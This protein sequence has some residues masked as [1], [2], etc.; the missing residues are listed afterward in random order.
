MPERYQYHP[1]QDA[2]DTRQAIEHHF[3]WRE[4]RQPYRYAPSADRVL[5][6]EAASER[7]RVSAT[8][9]VLGLLHDLTPPDGQTPLL[10][11][12]DEVRARYKMDNGNRDAAASYSMR[13]AWAAAER[14]RAHTLELAR[15]T[16]DW[17]LLAI[18]RRLHRVADR[19]EDA[20]PEHE[21]PL[22]F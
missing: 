14:M 8:Q 19:V 10:L 13:N 20:I 17:R 4:P 18:A 16:D 1:S 22:P 11:T 12:A 3:E 5:Q 21:R 6:D 2:R 15:A 9:F 7:A